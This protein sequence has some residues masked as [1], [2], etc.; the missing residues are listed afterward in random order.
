MQEINIE[1]IM[2]EIRAEIKEKGYKESDLSFQ[3]I[4]IPKEDTVLLTEYNENELKNCLHSANA[5][6]RVDYYRPIEGNGIKAVGKKL[7]RKL[8]KP[9]V[10]HLCVSQET[11]N[12]NTAKTLNQMN[13]Y[14]Q[15]LEER[16]AEL[17][18]I[19]DEGK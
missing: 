10:Y 19:V 2:Q 8:I 3:D 7:V 13:L 18:K 16:I 12:A 4:A 14:I 15:K 5:Y 9:V 1:E 6:T 11:F 17:E